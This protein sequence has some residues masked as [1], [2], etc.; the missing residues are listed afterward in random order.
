TGLGN[1]GTL[2]N[3]VTSKLLYE[4]P[5]E[6]YD[7]LESKVLNITVEQA[8]EALRKYLKTDQLT[9]LDVGDFSKK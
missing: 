6:D 7:A 4:I 9:T 2:M 8:N 3:L 1:D 5:L